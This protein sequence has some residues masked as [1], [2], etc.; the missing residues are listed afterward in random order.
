MPRNKVTVIG[1]GN[2]GATTAQRIAE[3]GLADVV[4]VDI[5]EGLPQGKGLDLSE[6]APVVGH[7]ARITGTNDYADTAGSDII[8]VT[9][10]LARQPGMSRDDLLAK[11]AGI[12]GAV[13]EQAARH[14]PNAIL[15]IVTNPLDAMCHVAMKASG[16]PRERVLGMAG[17]LDSARFRTFIAQE[18]GVSVE[19][20]HAF[21]LGGHGDTM[22][23]L[24]RYSTVAGVPIT[25]LLSPDRVKALEERTA[26]GG[27]EVVALLK[28]GS[29]FYAPAASTF[30]MV[31]SILL[32]RKRVLPCAV[33]LQGEFGTD[34][35]FVGV[36]VV[37]GCRR[38]GA[39]L[40]DRADRRRAGRIRRVGR[41][42]PGAGRQSRLTGRSIADGA[43]DRRAVGLEQR[44]PLHRPAH[45]PI[46]GKAIDGL[47]LGQWTLAQF[48]RQHAAE[49]TVL[50]DDLRPGA[51][52]PMDGDQHGVGLLAQ[53]VPFEQAVGRLPRTDGVT[54]RE[55]S[56][57]DDRQRVLE[58][59]RQPLA[60][61]GEAFVAEALEQVAVVQLDGRFGAARIVGQTVLEGGHVEV[62]AG[63]DP[64]PDRVR[65]DVEY[66]AGPE[67]RLGQALADEPQCLS[68]R[69]G[70]GPI[71]IRPQ[72][73]RDRLARPRPAG[74]DEQREQRLGMSTRQADVAVVGRPGI[75]AAEE[76]DLEAHA[77]DGGG[78][79]H[80]RFRSASRRPA[81]PSGRT[82][83]LDRIV[84]MMSA[85]AGP[86][87][88]RADT[89]R[90]G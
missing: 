2:V 76:I 31:E 73:G 20:T 34:G 19:D 63:V 3:A 80:R 90:V 17:V 50:A 45:R 21:V 32:D 13:V 27:A 88:G 66:L 37:L 79:R 22:V 62:D 53:R 47:R 67:P 48:A 43:Q 40:R 46:D 55:S 35:L 14:S 75:E 72:V 26:N 58:A 24:S 23:P 78:A 84:A 39:R 81:R 52:Q 44:G 85:D 87:D 29:A 64:D 36:P 1:A 74:E 16:F 15:I 60:L 42:R 25:E 65:V 49:A 10:G 77:R 59:I 33:L 51:D 12:V 5:V 83:A 18:L 4:L 41:G 86:G 57:G 9:S 28:T 61:G 38:H 69:S 56:L 70:R 8:V 89:A 68:E 82:W 6:A 11:N 54:G 71:R 30:E 7:D